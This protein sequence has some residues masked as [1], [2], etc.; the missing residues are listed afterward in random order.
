MSERH[1]S[2]K[3]SGTLAKPSNGQ[4]QTLQT[5]H[6]DVD[7]RHLRPWMLLSLDGAARQKD[8]SMASF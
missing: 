6:Q 7:Y 4:V 8:L 1:D 2:T 3:I 5:S